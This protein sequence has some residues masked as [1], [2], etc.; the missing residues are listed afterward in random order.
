MAAGAATGIAL[1]LLAPGLAIGGPA[2]AQALFGLGALPA[3]WT[4]RRAIKAAES[5][6][7]LLLQGHKAGTREAHQL[8]FLQ[9]QEALQRLR[10]DTSTPGEILGEACALD[11]ALKL[12]V[13][14]GV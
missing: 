13:E 8:A 7:W 5:P 9:A 4:A 6:T 14:A 11:E 1:G 2:A 3:M 10:G 12:E